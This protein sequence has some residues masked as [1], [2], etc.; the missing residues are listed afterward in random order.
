MTKDL[1][2]KAARPW[3]MVYLFF[4]EAVAVGVQEA[5]G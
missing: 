1:S 5:T 2:G 4:R 3:D